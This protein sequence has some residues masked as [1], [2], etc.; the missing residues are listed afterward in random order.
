MGTI[1]VT[2]ITSLKT[3]TARATV[4]SGS[5]PDSG[6]PRIE[7]VPRDDAT[8]EGELAA[9]AA[10]DAV[11]LQ[12]HERNKAATPAT[13]RQKEVDSEERRQGHDQ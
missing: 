8:P 10:V 9:L 5:P 3:S 7:Y 2:G 13:R 6:G 4:S 12:A 1:T 11:I